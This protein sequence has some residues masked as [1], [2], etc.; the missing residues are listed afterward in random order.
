[1]ILDRN[2]F[3]DEGIL[4]LAKVVGR[5]RLKL[6]SIAS[7]NMTERSYVPLLAELAKVD[8]L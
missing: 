3:K 1:L 4:E 2:S 7:V 5:L 8:C 6:L